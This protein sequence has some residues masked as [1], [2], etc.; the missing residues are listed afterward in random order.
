MVRMDHSHPSPRTTTVVLTVITGTVMIPLDITIVAVALTRLSEVTG[1]SLPVIQWIATGYTL[2]LATVIP[3]AAW[4][5][6]RYGGRRVFLTA[7]A[8]LVTASALVGLAWNVESMI[9]FR[10]LQ[11]LG[12]GF[13]MPAAMTLT[14]RAAAPG[15]RGRAMAMLGLPILVGP[16]LGPVLGGVVLD[17]LS[18]RWLFW[19]NVPIGLVAVTLGLRNLPA[20][21]GDRAPICGCRTFCPTRRRGDGSTARRCTA[22]PRRTTAWP[23]GSWGGLPWPRR[24]CAMP[25]RWTRSTPRFCC[26]AR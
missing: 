5:I 8:V 21:P 18:W 11:G 1:A 25:R 19:I 4:A 24:G 17:G 6:G 16:V 13:V 22:P 9:V 7:L 26:A 3:T 23:S 12:G 20:A 2:A 15:E 14:L 10:V